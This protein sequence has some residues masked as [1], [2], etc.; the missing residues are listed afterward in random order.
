MSLKGTDNFFF[1]ASLP[2][3]SDAWDTNAK[4]YAYGVLKRMTKSPL[5]VQQEVGVDEVDG[6]L[7][8]G[9]SDQILELESLFHILIFNLYI[10][11]VHNRVNNRV[12]TPHPRPPTPYPSEEEEE[13]VD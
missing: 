2:F 4:G 7:K 9:L 11:T 5:D 6:F 12:T 8:R 3:D 10:K 13:I 1:M